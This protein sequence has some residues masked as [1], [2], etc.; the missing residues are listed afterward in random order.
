MHWQHCWLHCGLQRSGELPDLAP[1]KVSRESDCQIGLSARSSS[2]G[3]TDA[4][5]GSGGALS[6][7]RCSGLSC[8]GAAAAGLAEGGGGS[9]TARSLSRMSTGSAATSAYFDAA[10]SLA[11]EQQQPGSGESPTAH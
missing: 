4:A 1:L 8:S 9:V 10:E 2:G 7:R 3:E 11:D 6:S 5:W